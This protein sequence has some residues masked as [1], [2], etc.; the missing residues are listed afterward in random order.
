MRDM[1]MA[2]TDLIKKSLNGLSGYQSYGGKSLATNLDAADAVIDR[3][4]YTE[5]IWDRSRS[6]WVIKFLVCSQADA[7]LRLRQV[8]AEIFSKRTSMQ[9]A[10]FSYARSLIESKLKR[11]EALEEKD[12]DKKFLL[13]IEAAEI[14]WGG[15]II[16][17]KL[18]G[19]L[20]EIETLGDIHDGLMKK[21][22]GVDITEKEFEKAQ[23]KAHIRRVIMQATREVRE[24]GRIK[25]GNQEYLNQI[26]I[27]VSSCIKEISDF[28]EREYA[29]SIKDDSLLH[30][31]VDDFAERYE[32]VSE[33]QSRF[34]GIDSK[35]NIDITF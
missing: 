16:L 1:I 6:Q 3:L 29:S 23:T 7:W 22:D 8:S 2:S 27:S 15:A 30:E 14:E 20:K 17:E 11:Q 21:M 4:K 31:F 28:V 5:K 12:A 19:N 35:A 9:T 18:S 26:G 34:L 25:V 24:T 32:A 10:K 33:N 13:E